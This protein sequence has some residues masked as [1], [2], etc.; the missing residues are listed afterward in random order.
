VHSQSHFGHRRQ[1]LTV[2]PQY[3]EKMHGA[4]GFAWAQGQFDQEGTLLM[5]FPSPILAS[6]VVLAAA[7]LLALRSAIFTASKQAIK[8]RSDRRRSPDTK[9]QG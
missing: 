4:A 1:I 6:A 2:L 7:T 3:K 5:T 8:V 9:T